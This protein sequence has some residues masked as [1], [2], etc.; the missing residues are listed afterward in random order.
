MDKDFFRIYNNYFN[1]DQFQKSLDYI[2]NRTIPPNLIGATRRNRFI[3]NLEPFK[4]ENGTIIYSKDDVVKKV[5]T[6]ESKNDFLNGLMELYENHKIGQD[7]FYDLIQEK[8]IGITQE[9]IKT[10]FRKN[11]NYQ[12]TRKIKPVGKSQRIVSKAPNNIWQIDHL[13]LNR[14]SRSYKYLLNVIDLFSRKT[15]AIPVS[16][17]DTEHTINAIASILNEIAPMNPKMIQMDNEQE[18]QANDM[19]RF[20]R[21]KGIKQKFTSTYKPQDNGAVERL[22]QTLMEGLKKYFIRNN[23][24]NWGRFIGDVVLNY[25]GTKHSTTEFAPDEIYNQDLPEDIKEQVIK[26][27]RKN[28]KIVKNIPYKVGDYVRI[29]R[30]KTDPEF[31]L[32]VKSKNPKRNLYTENW[33]RE[34]YKIIKV[35]K[36]RVPESKQ[37]QYALEDMEGNT[38]IANRNPKKFFHNDLLV[39]SEPTQEE[40]QQEE[41]NVMEEE[42]VRERRSQPREPRVPSNRRRRPAARL[43]DDD[44]D[45]EEQISFNVG[46]RVKV[47]FREGSR[48][49]FYEG[50]IRRILDNGDYQIKYDGYEE[51]EIVPK[52]MERN[53]TK[54]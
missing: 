4:M 48:N 12:L 53:M 44:D 42:Q 37:N 25:N 17:K 47:K 9:D 49:V 6:P 18:Y 29:S 16:S 35:Y 40:Q 36:T 11:E 26:N 24:K 38:L 27:V 52:N 28:L 2:Q 21:D 39:T 45:D 20:L 19:K 7:K 10:L 41:A 31:R 15:W 1:E 3:E 30:F 14:T 5:I 13:E 34:K 23:N 8:Y 32:N 54:I 50:N 43:R 51:L 22:N 33:S 46:D